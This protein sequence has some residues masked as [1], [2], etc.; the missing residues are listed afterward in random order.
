MIT[1]EEAIAEAEDRV[2]ELR[3]RREWINKEMGGLPVIDWP[4]QIFCLFEGVCP[5]CSQDV[6]IVSVGGTPDF[7]EEQ[8]F[9]G[10]YTT[11]TWTCTQSG[12]RRLDGG[13]GF[14]CKNGHEH[15]VE[16]SNGD[17]R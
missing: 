2:Q 13:V 16:H 11:Y 3:W 17:W 5:V 4:N 8:Q 12:G 9:S 14:R 15:Y 6:D 1:L 7:L 10:E